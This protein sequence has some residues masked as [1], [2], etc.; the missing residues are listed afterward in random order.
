MFGKRRVILILLTLLVMGSVLCALSATV[1][2]L[3]VG[4][5]LQGW[6]WESFPWASRCSAI[7][8]RHDASA[9]RSPSSAPLW[10]S[11]P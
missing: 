3:I 7:P 5:G 2:P 11:E 10:A 8:S 9:R 1:V 6:A 4:R